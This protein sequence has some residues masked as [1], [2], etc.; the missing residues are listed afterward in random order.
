MKNPNI[1]N[2]R[3]VKIFVVGSPVISLVSAV[4]CLSCIENLDGSLGVFF[5]DFFAMGVGVLY[6]QK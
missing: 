5:V 4:S 1:T 2:K 6:S 3:E